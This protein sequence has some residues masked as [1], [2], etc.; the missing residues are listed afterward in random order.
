MHCSWVHFVREPQ[1]FQNTRTLFFERVTAVTEYY[2]V[3]ERVVQPKESRARSGPSETK[4]C[5]SLVS[6]PTRSGRTAWSS[7]VCFMYWESRSVCGKFALPE[8]VVY[9]GADTMETRC[10]VSE[11]PDLVRLFFRLYDSLQDNIVFSD[12]GNLFKEKCASVLEALGFT[13]EVY[14]AAVHQY[15][16]EISFG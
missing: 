14:P 16:G 2:V 11:G 10:F 12:G 7:K 15:L 3:L 5:V 8:R 4:H 9:I 1:G 13:H 6:A